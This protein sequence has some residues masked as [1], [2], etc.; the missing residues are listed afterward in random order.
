V[1]VLRSSLDDVVN[2]TEVALHED[3]LFR[4]HVVGAGL[5]V[6]AN[7]DLGGT[8]NTQ[9]GGDC[10]VRR[11]SSLFGA[12]LA[13]HPALSI[14]VPILDIELADEQ[15]CAGETHLADCSFGIRIEW[16]RHE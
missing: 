1:G 16:L 4:R 9:I 5:Y 3:E 12:H 11:G 6:S 13:I 15:A 10:T 14:G 2:V 8:G 7:P